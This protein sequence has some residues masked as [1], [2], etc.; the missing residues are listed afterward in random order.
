MSFFGYQVVKFLLRNQ[1]VQIQICTLNHL[2]KN[3][4]ISKLSKI[5]SNLSE[6]FK[7][8]KSSLLTVEGNENL[9]YFIS[10]LIVR[11]TS[12]HHVDELRELNLPT[13]VLVELSNHLIDSLSLGL[14]TE[15]V[16]S[17]FEF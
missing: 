5:F 16:D 1:I 2:L 15:R 6:V 8:Y 9:V 3:C 11:R 17:N 4:V 13:T 7:S 14:N 12:G 10:A